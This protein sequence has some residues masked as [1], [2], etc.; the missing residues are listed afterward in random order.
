MHLVASWVLARELVDLLVGGD[1]GRVGGVDYWQTSIVH[2]VILHVH[3]LRHFGKLVIGRVG[4]SS[5]IL[6]GFS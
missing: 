3:C 5:V 2:P 1:R 6:L 4:E